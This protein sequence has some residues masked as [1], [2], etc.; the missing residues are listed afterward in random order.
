MKYVLF[1][2]SFFEYKLVNLKALLSLEGTNISL[3][4]VSIN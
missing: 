2:F 1:V 4:P 3:T